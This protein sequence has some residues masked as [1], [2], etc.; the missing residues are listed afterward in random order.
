MYAAVDS[1]ST[2]SAPSGADRSAV[3]ARQPQLVLDRRL[4]AP[5]QRGQLGQRQHRVVGGRGAQRGR[6]DP[7]PGGDRLGVVRVDPLH[8]YVV[9]RR[10]GRLRIGH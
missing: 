5:D 6:E 10:S 1:R 4:P 2:S 8:P 3:G 7:V 9:A